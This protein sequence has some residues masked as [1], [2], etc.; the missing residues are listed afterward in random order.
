MNERM[1]SRVEVSGAVDSPLFTFPYFSC[2]HHLF[3]LIYGNHRGR[4][5]EEGAEWLRIVVWP[6]AA[7]FCFCSFEGCVARGRLPLSRRSP[8]SGVVLDCPGF[9]RDDDEDLFH[10]FPLRGERSKAA[11]LHCI[12]PASKC[13]PGLPSRSSSLMIG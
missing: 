1:S 12:F 8:S 6:A 5:G 4:G 9:G 2:V 3:E 11:F 7:T 10:V 13:G